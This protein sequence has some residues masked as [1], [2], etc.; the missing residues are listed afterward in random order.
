MLVLC[1]WM[2]R[3]PT[4]RCA[5]VEPGCFDE[6]GSWVSLLELEKA[7]R[8]ALVRLQTKK[9]SADKNSKVPEMGKMISPRV[10]VRCEKLRMTRTVGVRMTAPPRPIYRLGGKAT[11]WGPAARARRRACGGSRTTSRPTCCPTSWR[12]STGGAAA[13]RPDDI[14]LNVLNNSYSYDRM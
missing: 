1:D 6:V 4:A 9:R 3:R 7:C 13:S 12:T 11:P 5:L 14:Y 8:A 2:T 10:A